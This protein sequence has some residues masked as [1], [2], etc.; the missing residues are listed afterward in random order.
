DTGGFDTIQFGEGVGKEDI[1]FFMQNARLYLQ[2]SD[3][4]SVTIAGQSK[5]DNQIERIE[6]NDGS[7]MTNADI[8][9]IVQ[10]MSA[11]AS[12]KGIWKPDN[13][14]IRNNEQMMQIVTSGWQI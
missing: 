13:N 14:D 1:S 5:D 10:Q 11:F 7:Y 12:E 2:Y 9:L 6:L 4:D 3:T 8:D